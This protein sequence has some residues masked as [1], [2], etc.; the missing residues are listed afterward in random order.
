VEGPLD[1]GWPDEFVASLEALADYA[2]DTNNQIL[3]CRRTGVYLVRDDDR[4]LVYDPRVEGWNVA[5]MTPPAPGT[6]PVDGEAS[7]PTPD[8]DPA[9]SAGAFG[10]DPDVAPGDAP[11]RPGDEE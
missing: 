1:Y 11:D 4:T 10:F 6:P 7:G 9:D 3:E 5:S 8:L 2:I